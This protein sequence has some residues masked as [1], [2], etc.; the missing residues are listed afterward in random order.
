M[1]NLD[2]TVDM[3]ELEAELALRKQE[4]EAVEE[5]VEEDGDAVEI[6]EDPTN[7]FRA[8]ILKTL[9]AQGITE[10]DL[11][12]AKGTF[13]K[14]FSFPWSE[15][16]IYIFRPL[17][18]KEWNTIREL[19]ENNEHLNYLVIRQGCLHPKF[20]SIAALE[21]DIAGIQDILSE[22]ILRSSGFI[23]LEEAMATIQE[24]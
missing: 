3:S 22:V 4:L 23:S 14:V 20:S 21:E 9:E 24:L 8:D 11:D 12:A 2:T 18:R 17:Y 7:P 13:G 6:E 19:A 16:K 15:E 1:S 10:A 5:P